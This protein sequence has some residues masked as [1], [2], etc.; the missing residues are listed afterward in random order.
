MIAQ[1]TGVILEVS[2]TSVLLR[3]GPLVLEVLVASNEVGK[4]TDL[5]TRHPERDTTFH[6]TF[7]LEG[8]ASGGNLT[9]RLIGFS[10]PR[11]LAFFLKFITVKG[12]GPKKALKALIEPAGVIAAAIE[13][14]DAKFLT[15]LPQIG[16]RLAEQ[17][18]AELAGKV[19]EYV[20]IDPTQSGRTTGGTVSGRVAV[21]FAPTEEDAI[22]S[23]VS[24][25]ERR[26]DAEQLLVRARETGAAGT[27]E[28]L[29]AMLRLRSSGPA[30]R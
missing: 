22:A 5:A 26:P 1:V 3:V 28:L 7:Y 18:V 20:V 14:K 15:K 2:P 4:L 19:Q 6:T 21:L 27:A 25:G 11:D 16:A 13:R 24:L 17:I 30:L 8:D 23:L 10:N 12:I 9:P 29:R